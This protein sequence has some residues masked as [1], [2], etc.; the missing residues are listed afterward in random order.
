MGKGIKMSFD[1]RPCYVGN[2]KALFHK[3]TEKTKV[4]IKFD[5][6]IT[7]E[8]AQKIYDIYKEQGI[9]P[10]G[11]ST[12]EKKETYA[13]VEYEDGTVEEVK[14]TKVRFADNKM[15]EYAFVKEI[16]Q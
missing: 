11:C 13:I 2:K 8:N 9:L 1:L 3:F 7:T 6:L 16:E 15:R 14:P 4:I 12:A 5:R 10:T